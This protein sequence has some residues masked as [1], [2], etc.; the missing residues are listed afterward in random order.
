MEYLP[1]MHYSKYSQ[2]GLLEHVHSFGSIRSNHKDNI[3]KIR[4]TLHQSIETRCQRVL[5]IFYMS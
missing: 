2:V 1:S 3:H 5:K 4:P